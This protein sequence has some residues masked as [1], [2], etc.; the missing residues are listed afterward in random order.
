MAPFPIGGGVSVR[1]QEAE[2]IFESPTWSPPPPGKIDKTPRSTE[3]LQASRRGSRERQM[4][5]FHCLS[6][7]KIIIRRGGG[8]GNP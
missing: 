3:R 2:I 6:Y 5:S 4:P 7:K 1:D 8:G